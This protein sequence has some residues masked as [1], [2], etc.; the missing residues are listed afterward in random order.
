MPAAVDHERW[1]VQRQLAYGHQ[2][3][4][5]VLVDVEYGRSLSPAFGLTTL[6]FADEKAQF[7]TLA[8]L[9]PRPAGES[10]MLDAS[11]SSQYILNQALEIVL[12]WTA[13]IERRVAIT[14]LQ[15]RLQNR[16]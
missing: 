1:L 7:G 4:D 6:L 11:D 5:N 3:L 15:A 12:A 13:E 10:P 9:E 16:L 2:I 8:L 14:P